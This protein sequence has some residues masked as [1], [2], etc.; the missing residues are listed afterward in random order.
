MKGAVSSL[1]MLT[2]LV[3]TRV[4]ALSDNVKQELIFTEKSWTVTHLN[5][6]GIDCLWTRGDTG[7]LQSEAMGPDGTGVCWD[8]K[9]V[10]QAEKLQKENKL[11]W[12]NPPRFEYEF[13]DKNKCYYRIDKIIGLVDFRPG[14]NITEAEVNECRKDTSKANALRLATKTQREVRFGGYIAT[15]KNILGS[16]VLACYTGSIDSDNK[17]ISNIERTRRYNAILS[18]YKGDDKDTQRIN[19][20]YTFADTNLRDRYPLDTE[21]QYRAKVCAEMVQKGKL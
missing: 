20:A 1:V 6:L 5:E 11:V 12:H 9:A 10:A 15:E 16:V 13:G 3:A 4:M 2:L 8:A 7:H 14:D 21:G 18:L 17:R 19:K